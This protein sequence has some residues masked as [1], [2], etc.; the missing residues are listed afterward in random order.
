MCQILYNILEK[1]RGKQWTIVWTTQLGKFYATV[2]ATVHCQQMLDQM[3]SKIGT[4][5]MTTSLIISESSRQRS[6]YFPC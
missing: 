1:L 4:C 3:F 2:T 5:H 6:K